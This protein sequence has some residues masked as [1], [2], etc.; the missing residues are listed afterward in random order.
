MEEVLEDVRIMEKIL[1]SLDYKFELIVVIIE[2]TEDLIKMTIEQLEG[3]LQAYEERHE[4]KHHEDVEGDDSPIEEV[5]SPRFSKFGHYATKC[6]AP[7][8]RVE[9]KMNYTETNE[10]ESATL[11]LEYKDSKGE[12]QTS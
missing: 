9:E 6:W 11:L 4:K 2:E 3:S 1:R 12:A 10:E 8:N 7:K 5:I